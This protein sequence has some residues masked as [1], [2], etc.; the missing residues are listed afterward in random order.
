MQLKAVIHLCDEQFLIHNPSALSAD[1]LK[2]II[3][4]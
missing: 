3:Y 4:S 1:L 2:I